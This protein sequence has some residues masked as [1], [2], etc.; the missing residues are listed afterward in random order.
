MKIALRLLILLIAT[1]IAVGQQSSESKALTTSQEEFI[2]ICRDMYSAFDTYYSHSD[3]L[4]DG[5]ERKTYL[6]ENDP[7]KQFVQRLT[8]FAKKQHGTHTGLMA[9][10]RLVLLGAGGGDRGNARDLGRRFALSRLPDYGESPELPE[11]LRYL[12]SGNTEPAVEGFLRALIASDDISE[13]NRLFAKYMLGRWILSQVNARDFWKRRLRELD[14]GSQSRYPKERE[15]LQVSLSGALSP[16]KLERLEREALLCLE[17]VSQSQSAV[18]QPGIAT[19]DEKYFIIRVDAAKTQTMPLVTELASGLLF[20]HKHLQIGR[21]AP[22]LDITLV[23]GEHWSLAQQRGK[24]VVIQF[25]FKGCGPCEAMYP[26]LRL[27]R[28]TYPDS[29]AILSIMADEEKSQTVEAIESGKLT[30]SICWD[31]HRGA[32]ATQW[33]VKGFPSVYVVG[34]DGTIAAYGL[35]G[36]SLKSKIAKL[37]TS[38]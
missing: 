34:P 3:T 7:S 26:D 10:R 1:N 30:W 17:S 12:D 8:E 29:V 22:S 18:R 31:G 27:L 23:S 15:F 11:I 14:Q 32:I 24:T 35:R 38:K 13:Q 21:P 5:T 28:E 33:A 36:D 25:S 37:V 20:R 6:K 19:V 9:L 2:S 4:K 16:D